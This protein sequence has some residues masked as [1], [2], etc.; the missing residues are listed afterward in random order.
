MED[1][2]IQ[3][4]YGDLPPAARVYHLPSCR[5]AV[6]VASHAGS[7]NGHEVPIH[8]DGDDAETFSVVHRNDLARLD[9]LN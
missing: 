6:T 3:L 9:R 5:Y 7:L 4:S 2:I 1:V 8:F